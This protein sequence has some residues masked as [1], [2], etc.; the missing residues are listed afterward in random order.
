MYCWRG[1]LEANALAGGNA[2]LRIRTRLTVWNWC[3]DIEQA[4][5]IAALLVENAVRHSG[6]PRYGRLRICLA[7]LGTNELTVD[8]MDPH[9]HFPGFEEA[10]MWEP[11]PGETPR[12]LYL[13]RCYGAQ[14]T[15]RSAEDGSGKTVQALIKPTVESA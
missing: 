8:V 15:Y 10:V 14:V 5:Q 7:V 12:G 6:I 11:R 1:T 9:P 4:S 13:A 2:R 3:G